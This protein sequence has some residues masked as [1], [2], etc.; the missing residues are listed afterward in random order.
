MFERG[1]ADATQ[2]LQD[3]VRSP[4]TP[5][6]AG[7]DQSDPG[8][9]E[10]IVGRIPLGLLR[11]DQC[12]AKHPMLAES[13][14][15]HFLIARLKNIERQQGVWKEKGTGEGHDGYPIGQND[16]RVHGGWLGRSIR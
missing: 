9:V 13:V 5:P 1:K 12:D 2:T 8:Y 11:F 14:L 15:E 7:P 3:Q 16:R 4:V 6:N 10:K